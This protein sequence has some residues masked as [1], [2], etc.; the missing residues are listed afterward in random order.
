MTAA[1]TRWDA[2]LAIFAKLS[3]HP[4][5]QGVQVET[6]WP[7]DDIRERCI[8]VGDVTGELEIPVM[9]AGRKFYN[10]TFQVPTI[11]LVRSQ[12]SL[13]AVAEQFWAMHGA[14]IDCIQAAGAVLVEVEEVLTVGETVATTSRGPVRDDDWFRMFGSL[15][16]EVNSRYY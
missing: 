8:V 3:A 5:L 12:Q 10:D 14:V 16:L 2:V 7:G 15:T 1:A 9:S 11:I 4:D 6:G 13:A